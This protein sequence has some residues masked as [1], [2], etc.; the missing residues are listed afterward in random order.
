MIQN[1]D[2]WS[3]SRILFILKKAQ[4]QLLWKFS[5][6][7]PRTKNEIPHGLDDFPGVLKIVRISFFIQNIF[8][9]MIFEDFT[10]NPVWW[11]FKFYI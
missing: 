8:G 10:Q 2:P 1:I 5:N 6:E 4:D 11:R 3:L 9:Q 7:P